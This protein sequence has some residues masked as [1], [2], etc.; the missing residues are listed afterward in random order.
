MMDTS[1][2]LADA[3]FKIAKASDVTINIDFNKIP[4][5]PDLKIFDNWEQLL[6]FGGEDYG[7]VFAYDKSFEPDFSLPEFNVV[8]EVLS[9]SEYPLVI[10]NNDKI[11][12]YSTIDEFTFNHFS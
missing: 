7:L 3:L 12:K 8:G 6:L 5:S 11:L 4:V 9:K 1:D 2:G 10:K